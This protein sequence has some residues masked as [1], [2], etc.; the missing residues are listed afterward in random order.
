MT[1]GAQLQPLGILSL[2][3]G[4]SA[5]CGFV[6]LILAVHKLGNSLELRDLLL[7]LLLLSLS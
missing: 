1:L 7:G 5:I 6:L 2:V 3:A 4:P